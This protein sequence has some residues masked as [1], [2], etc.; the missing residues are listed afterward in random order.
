[1]ADNWS[2]NLFHENKKLTVINFFGGPGCGK[3]TT[4]AELFAKM[5]KANYKVELVHEVAK[6]F[7]WE[8]AQ[9]LFG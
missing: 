2:R 7:I 1:M 6:D 5:K 9:H 3:S 8:E 4:A